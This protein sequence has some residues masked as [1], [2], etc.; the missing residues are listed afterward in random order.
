M[1]WCPLQ[2]ILAIRM[3]PSVFSS[4]GLCSPSLP[5]KPT[6][7]VSLRRI[8]KFRLSHF[9]FAILLFVTPKINHLLHLRLT[10]KALPHLYNYFQLTWLLECAQSILPPSEEPTCG[11]RFVEVC[12]NLAYVD[13]RGIVICWLCWKYIFRDQ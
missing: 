7:G 10:S 13:M 8:C 9:N 5:L 12:K 1:D 2:E 6:L 11:L 3:R 4:N